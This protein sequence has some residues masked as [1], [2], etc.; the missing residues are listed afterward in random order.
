MS[1]ALDSNCLSSCPIGIISLSKLSL[2]SL[3]PYASNSL[4]MMVSNDIYLNTISSLNNVL[5]NVE[6]M[7][8]L[9]FESSCSPQVLTLDID[10]IEKSTDKNE[11]SLKMK[12][13]KINYNTVNLEEDAPNTTVS[14]DHLNNKMVRSFMRILRP[15]VTKKRINKKMMLHSNKFVN[16][17]GSGTDSSSS[18]SKVAKG[19]QNMLSRGGKFRAGRAIGVVNN[20][21]YTNKEVVNK[22]STSKNKQSSFSSAGSANKK[23]NRSKRALSL[24][25]KSTK[26]STSASVSSLSCSSPTNFNCSSLLSHNDS[27]IN[28]NNYNVS[29]EINWYMLEELDHYYKILGKPSSCFP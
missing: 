14:K 9:A 13:P 29:K 22:Q 27:S 16:S 26:F 17:V 2:N 7:S 25:T 8:Q 5:S 6:K 19:K 18:S 4:N 3:T 12:F 23:S 28:S 21:S 1:I 15:I 20:S 24:I 11:T 10:T